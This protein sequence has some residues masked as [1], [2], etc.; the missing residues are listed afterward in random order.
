M[1]TIVVTGSQTGMGWATRVLL[2]RSG[3]RVIGVS[4]TGDAEVIA[5][6]STEAGVDHAVARIEA[7]AGGP[8]DGVF[9]NAGVDNENAPLVFGLNYF[10]VVRLLQA[11][12]PSLAQS[13]DG[14]VVVN[15]SN[16]VVITPGIPQDV[17]DALLADD[18][19]AALRLIAAQPHWTYQASKT[20]I[21]RW[22]RSHAVSASWAGSGISMNVL[23]P[24]VVL[25]PLIERDMQDPRKASGIRAL[26]APLGRFPG[27][28]NVAPLV[29]FLLV[30]DS[31]FI[32]GQYLIIDG[33]TEATWRGHESPRP[34]DIATDAFRALMQRGH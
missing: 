9:A 16:S 5:D 32:V 1:K 28:E 26:P 31:R 8:V 24:G 17:V 11:L 14:R 23:A 27:P 21:T 2:E 29:R 22:V 4:D 34:W 20:A 18:R 33:G 6:L 30:D 25:T 15:A 3:V 10:G 13:G 19:A 12:R 7:L